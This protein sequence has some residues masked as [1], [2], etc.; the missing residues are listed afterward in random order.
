MKKALL[1]LFSACLAYSFATAQGNLS[2]NFQIEAQSYT[3]DSLIGAIK[4]P[5]KIRSNSFLN[6]IYNT[7]KF[8]VGARYEAYYKPLL[9]FDPRYEGSGIS[10]RYASYRS[11]KIDVTAGDFYEQFGSGVIFRAY[12][13][14][15]LGFDNAVDGLRVK[16]RP[17]AGIEATALIGKMRSF[18]GKSRGIVRAG[19]V[20]FSLNS[21]FTETLEEAPQLALGGSVVSKYE[22][23]DNSQFRLPENV[24]AYSLRGSVTGESYSAELEYAYKHND[25]KTTNLYTFS[26]GHA[27]ILNTSYFTEGFGLSLN[28]HSLD[29]MDFRADRAATANNLTINYIP[30]L[31]RQHAYRLATLYPFATQFNG[32]AGAQLEATINLPE[33]T[34]LGGERGGS[35]TLNYSRLHSV[36]RD[37]INKYKYDSP[38]ISVGDRLFFQDFNIEYLRE[39]SKNFKSVLTFINLIY[40]KDVI[41]SGGGYRYG[42]IYSNILVADLT[43]KLSD[44]NALRI[45]GQHLWSSRDSAVHA[46]ENTNGNWLFGLAELTLAPNWYITVYDEYNYDN[47]FEDLRLHYLNGSL[48]YLFESTRI[49]LGYGRQRSGILCVGGVCRYVPASNGFSLSVSSSF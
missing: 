2:G 28:L 22:E 12:E 16:F 42:K 37:T 47:E 45:E 10:Y 14:R 26:P 6:L 19:D 9:G 46:G 36:K 17:A 40:D 30:A 38:L 20:N 21:I 11:E 23:D 8:E 24:L 7:G 29:N 32:E 4:V 49:Q 1:V 43:F 25:P 18:W 33:K 34:F 5:E 27:L 13:E 44:F 41:E 31:T 48:A 15:A 3:A 39:W 35:L